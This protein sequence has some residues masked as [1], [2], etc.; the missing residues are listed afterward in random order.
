MSMLQTLETPT[1]PRPAAFPSTTGGIMW[2]H[3]STGAV[4]LMLEA[5]MDVMWWVWIS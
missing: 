4:T 1:I 5:Y 2:K 3:V